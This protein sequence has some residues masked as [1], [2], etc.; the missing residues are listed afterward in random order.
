MRGIMIFIL[1]LF[2]FIFWV[3]GMIFLTPITIIITVICMF[4]LLLKLI[5][6]PKGVDNVKGL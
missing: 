2:L 3:I 5:F 1:S 6:T 4:I